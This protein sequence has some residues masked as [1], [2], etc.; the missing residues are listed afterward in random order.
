MLVSEK[1]EKKN[2]ETISLKGCT[3]SKY[4][5]YLAQKKLGKSKVGIS[6][7]GENEGRNWLKVKVI[8]Y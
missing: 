2:F 8:K 1:Y 7:R 5:S 6:K 3:I 4:H